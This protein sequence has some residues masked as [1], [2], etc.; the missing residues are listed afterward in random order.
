MEYNYQS[1][2]M[3]PSLLQCTSTARK[4]SNENA[5]PPQAEYLTEYNVGVT[6]WCTPNRI[7]MESDARGTRKLGNVL[8]VLVSDY[9]SFEANGNLTQH[10]KVFVSA[11][12][13]Q[14]HT[15]NIQ[16]VQ[17]QP[18]NSSNPKNTGLRIPHRLA[19]SLRPTHPSSTYLFTILRDIQQ[20]R[21]QIKS[22]PAI[23]PT[24]RLP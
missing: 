10:S 6:G 2:Q 11:P 17:F 13:Y 8:T 22:Q 7:E 21:K 14:I 15:S 16:S 18:R 24:I 9:H 4:V 19:V 12:R 20:T 1:I 23:Q 5:P 3:S